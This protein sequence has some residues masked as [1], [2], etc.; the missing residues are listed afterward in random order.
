MAHAVAGAS[1]DDVSEQLSHQECR[2]LARHALRRCFGTLEEHGAVGSFHPA[3]EHRVVPQAAV[4]EHPVGSGHREQGDI[5]RP[6]HHRR[7]G[8]SADAEPLG[9]LDGSR[10]A[11]GAEHLHRGTV[12]RRAQRRAHGHRAGSGMTVL[13]KPG[14]FGRVHRLVEPGDDRGGRV[15]HLER[16]GVDERLERGSGLP[17]RLGRAI[18]RALGEVA[19]TDERA[20]FARVRV[21]RDERALQVVRRGAVFGQ[22]HLG[23]RRVPE[24]RMP[25]GGVEPAGERRLGGRLHRW[26]DRR[27]DPEAA[28]RDELPAEAVDQFPGDRLPDVRPGR[29]AHEAVD[30]CHRGIGQLRGRVLIDRARFGHQPQHDGT[31]H[32][33]AIEVARGRVSRRRLDQARHERGFSRVELR[34]V[35]AE[36]PARGRFHSVQSLAE[37]HLVQIRLEDLGLG[38][39]PLDPQRENRLPQLASDGLLA[40]EEAQPRELL[41][42]RR[43]A[44]RAL[45]G[46]HV[47]DDRATDPPAVEA[48]VLVEALVLH[49]EHSLHEQ[50]RNLIERDLDTLLLR[51]G[52]SRLVV[53]VEHH[54]RDGHVA[55]RADPRRARC[56]DDDVG[57]DRDERCAGDDDSHGGKGVAPAPP[58]GLVRNGRQDGPGAYEGGVLHGH[59]LS[60]HGVPAR[61]SHEPGAPGARRGLARVDL[62]RRGSGQGFRRGRLQ[63][64]LVTGF[65]RGG[66]QPARH[67]A[68]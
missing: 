15:A 28:G 26:V 65:R 64:A 6:E 35:L 43:P 19:A 30:E 39:L 5:P 49:G 4:G 42:D 23:T 38:E 33:R 17:V 41:R 11:D 48:R 53:P 22:G 57:G 50:G 47:G 36:V 52:K 67:G 8:W 66:L 46:A 63:P 29:V 59:M 20:H 24:R 32:H 54:R 3:N 1:V 37:V 61:W 62:T 21:E 34:R 13:G 51:D 58:A 25:F 10:N 40:R 27:V 9:V 12:A 7:H 55:E 31:P 68:G 44:L 56:A 16:R 60:S 45:A 18:E 14:A 2:V